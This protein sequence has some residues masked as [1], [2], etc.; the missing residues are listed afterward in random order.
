MTNP[1][2]SFTPRRNRGC[3]NKILYFL[4]FGIFLGIPIRE[5]AAFSLDTHLYIATKVLDDALSGSISVCAGEAL[6]LAKP[7]SR[8]S[9]RYAI[10][11]STLVALKESPSAYLAGAL[12]PDVFPDF[13]TS[14]VT[15]HPGIEHGWGT[16][17][18]LRHLLAHAGS[19][20]DRAWVSGFLSHASS[21]VFAHSWVNHYAGGIFDLSKH[22]ESNEIE[23]RHFI[24]ERYIAD[25]TPRIWPKYAEEIDAPHEFVADQL[26]L[27]NPIS[28]QFKKAGAVTGHVVAIEVLHENVQKLYEDALVI[29][30]KINEI[31]VKKLQPLEVAKAKLKLAEE[32]LK[33][34]GKGLEESENLLKKR[35]ELIANAERALLDAARVIDENPGLITGWRQQMEAAKIGLDLHESGLEGIRDAFQV[36]RRATEEAQK[37]LDTTKKF[38][39]WWSFLGDWACKVS[40]SYTSAE[41][42]LKAAKEIFAAKEKLL[43]EALGA[44]SKLK[45]L[46]EELDQ[47]I[48]VAEKAISDAK[49][50]QRTVGAQ[51]EVYRAQRKL[52]FES[53]K[54]TRKAVDEAKK[55]AVQAQQLLDKVSKDL[56]PVID[57][58]ARYNPIVLFLQHWAADIRRASIGFSRASQDVAVHLL[59]KQGGNALEP[60]MKWYACWRPVLSAVPS[61]VPQTI[62][63]VA[64]IYTD[65]HDKLTSE[66]NK[67]VDSL[68]SLGWLIAPNVKIQQEFEKKI[69][70]PLGHEIRNALGHAAGEAVSFLANRQLA[71]LIELMGSKDRITDARLNGIYATD[72][73]KSRLLEIPDV[74][75]RVRLDA[76]LESDDDTVSE[77]RFPALYNAIVLSKLALLDAETLNAVYNDLAREADPL[78]LPRKLFVA[79]PGKPFNILLQAVSS[80]D[81]NQQW[82]AVGLPYPVSSGSAK[83]WP[84]KSRFGRSGRDGASSGFLF[85][86]DPKA[87]EV[88]FKRIFRGPLNPGMDSHPTILASYPFPSCER[89]PF[90]STTRPDGSPADSDLT[91]RLIG[92][93]TNS[94]GMYPVLSERIVTKAELAHLGRWELR[95]ARNEIFARYGYT[96]GPSELVGHFGSQSWYQPANLPSSEIVAK[97]SRAEWRNISHIRH[98][99]L[100]LRKR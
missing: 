38:T 6:A 48:G 20:N 28:A 81:G 80:I 75:A 33:L 86:G 100:K 95:V 54:A 67:V 76:G 44:I 18:F 4:V 52:D 63:T 11:A 27:A 2:F 60:Y 69:M 96:F 70:K 42:S 58:L 17:D 1:T 19:G 73:S 90:P 94:K 51:L 79:I 35:E 3:R 57:L 8:C 98:L 14:Q 12:G 99:E 29:S 13:I 62:C 9:K 61:E 45:K 78:A 88:A 34:A 85:W 92:N 22:V 5:S 72:D 89:H 26:M 16:D 31:G 40:P 23:V 66:I 87:R 39:C 41:L 46:R 59:A 97:L 77:D 65:M 50:T 30:N 36:A 91:C 7:G 68:G 10:P 25:R 71:E 74:A 43:N 53:V 93:N 47:K 55:V 56:A 15:V 24:L 84:E 49:I 82:Q 21:D 64:D 83:E 37:V 32:G